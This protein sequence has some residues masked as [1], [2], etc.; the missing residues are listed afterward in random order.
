MFK[1]TT[2]MINSFEKALN[3]HDK[4]IPTD[5]EK[6]IVY[7]Y[8]IDLAKALIEDLGND[9]VAVADIIKAAVPKDNFA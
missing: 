6:S 7:N 9:V 8:K 1:N 2:E 3:L 5:E 4:D